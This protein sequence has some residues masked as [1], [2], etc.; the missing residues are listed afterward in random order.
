MIN[1]PSSELNQDNLIKIK[2]NR[3]LYAA[4]IC[5][6]IYSVIEIIDCISLVLIALNLMPNL[7][8]SLDLI[9]E[10][11]F[12]QILEEQPI[13]FFPFFLS[14]TLMRI[15]SCIGILKNRMWGFYIG[16]ISLILTM[17]ITIG[18]GPIG[19]FE[20]IFCTLILFLLLI[21]YFGQKQIIT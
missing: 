17:L 14:F 9:G 6:L 12:A 19:F 5:F 11:Q 18:F 4:G 3:Y 1:M 21:G 2:K 16:L 13:L 15:F 20:L 10:G 8:L 7:Y